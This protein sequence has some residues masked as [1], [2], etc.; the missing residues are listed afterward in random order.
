MSLINFRRVPL[1]CLTSFYRSGSLE[2]LS[3]NEAMY[4][5]REFHIGVYYD[6]KTQCENTNLK[7]LKILR[8][9]QI[10]YVNFPIFSETTS[11]NVKFYCDLFSQIYPVLTKICKDILNHKYPSVLFGC[12][13]GKDR[14][15]IAAA[16]LMK[17]AL[18]DDHS[19][20]QDFLASK[21][22]IAEYSSFFLNKY[23][24]LCG[25]INL[26]FPKRSIIQQ[27]LAF[28]K[29]Q[30]LTDLRDLL[31]KISLQDSSDNQFLC[32]CKCRN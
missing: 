29:T 6:L 26:L 11:I 30:K 17:A 1:R 22:G 21:E 23:S 19:I 15:G 12:S 3:L 2:E 25:D 28:L 8:Q 32:K 20:I 24:K 9:A 10:R 13:V 14:T 5:R 4:L 18:C 31:C 16:I 7:F 27:F